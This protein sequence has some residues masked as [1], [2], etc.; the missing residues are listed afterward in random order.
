MQPTT[1]RVVSHAL[2]TIAWSCRCGHRRFVCSERFRINANGKLADIWLIYRCERCEAT[3]NV[4]VVERTPVSRIDEWLFSAAIVNDPTTARAL[5]RDVP[6]LR[7]AGVR[8]A[9][10]DLWDLVG[11]VDGG[12]T[13]EDEE[14]ARVVFDDPLLVRLDAVIASAM[15]RTRRRI[16]VAVSAGE[17][18]VDPPGRVDRLRL[19]SGTVHVRAGRAGDAGARSVRCP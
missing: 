9:D 10:G 2:P 7:R 14:A 12:L 8:L 11:V 17:L 18:C 3:K 19:W 1:A 16:R 5:A 4:T 6:M 13:D 15:G